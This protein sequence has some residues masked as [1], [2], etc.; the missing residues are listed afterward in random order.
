M[1][2]A[3]TT[4]TSEA[5]KLNKDIF[6]LEVSNHELLG[7]SYRAY[8]ANARSAQASAKKRGEVRGGGRKPWQQKGTGR[9]RIGST[10]APHWRGGGVTFGPTGDQN[11]TITIPKSAK[12]VAIKQAL[13]LKNQ[14]KLVQTFQASALNIKDGK[15]KEVLDFL[16]KQKADQINRVLVV[17]ANKDDKISRSASNLQNLKV[18]AANYLNV[19]D[20]LNADLILLSSD[21]LP[22]IEK[23]LLENTSKVGSKKAEEKIATVKTGDAKK[24]TKTNK[25]K[26]SVEDLKAKAEGGDK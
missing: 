7:R 1:A 11:Y 15:T 10:R 5:V 19:F 21:S 6:S 14:E 9:A 8:L 25:R 20:I 16:K 17:V 3:K 12:K 22:V 24:A 4:A 18:V 2:E 13:S 23:W 26:V